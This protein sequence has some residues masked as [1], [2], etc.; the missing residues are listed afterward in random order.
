MSLGAASAITAR[1]PRRVKRGHERAAQVLFPCQGT[2]ALFRPFPHFGRV[3]AEKLRRGGNR[4]AVDHGPVQREVMPFP[5]HAPGA[6]GR[7]R[8]EEGQVVLL[9]V[10]PDR[11][12]LHLREH[13]IERADGLGLGIPGLAQSRLDD[14]QRQ[15]LLRRVHQLERQPF[16]VLGD[17][18]P[19]EP[20]LAVE[21]V[22]RLGALAIVERLEELHCRR[23][24]RAGDLVGPSGG[25]S[26]AGGQRQDERKREQVENGSHGPHSCNA[27][28]FSAR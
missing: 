6:A 8:A 4:L 14:G 15:L 10:A 5:P 24:E 23:G 9:D 1:T 21:R 13:G 19:V 25:S 22:P 2:Q 28:L 11:V 3:A 16:T 20:L 12:F 27:T 7:G 17:V 26:A 18:V